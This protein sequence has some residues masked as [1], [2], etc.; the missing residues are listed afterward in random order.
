MSLSIVFDLDV[1]S[2]T[3]AASLVEEMLLS[4]AVLHEG[5]MDCLVLINVIGQ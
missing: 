3:G 2:P 5:L 1:F 4:S